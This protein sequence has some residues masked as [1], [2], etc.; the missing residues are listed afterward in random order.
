MCAI[1][2]LY[3]APAVQRPLRPDLRRPR[4][5]STGPWSLALAALLSVAGVGCEDPYVD[6]RAPRIEAVRPESA[7]AGARVTLLGTGFGLR[8][9][10]D[11]VWLGD[12]EL[13]VESWSDRAVLVRLPEREPGLTTVVVRAG[14]R[15][16]APYP[17]EVAEPPSMGDGG[18]SADDGPL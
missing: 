2:L 12:V 11:G 15:V 13:D 14:A 8:G 1:T 9:D 6:D 10:R 18:P 4:A 16:S 7:P 3:H 5:P 17:F